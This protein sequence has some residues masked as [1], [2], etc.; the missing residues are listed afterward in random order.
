M[1]IKKIHPEL[2]KA[3]FSDANA[4]HIQEIAKKYH[5]PREK[6]RCLAKTSGL[7]LLGEISL[8]KFPQ[9]L[10]QSCNLYPETAQDIAKD[11]NNAIFSKVEQ[12]LEKSSVGATLVVARNM[13]GTRPA[14]TKTQPKIKMSLQDK[15]RETI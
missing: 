1:I 6:M 8:N 3:L 2:H 9:A 5:L 7:V 14:P 13:A 4:K 11:V 15:Y 10:Q 12:Y